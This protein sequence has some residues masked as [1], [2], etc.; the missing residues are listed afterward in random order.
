MDGGAFYQNPTYNAAGGNGGGTSGIAGVLC[1]NAK[2]NISPGYGGQAGTQTAGGIAGAQYD[3][4]YIGEDGK[5]GI[6]GTIDIKIDNQNYY[7]SGAGRW[8]M[9]W[10]WLLRKL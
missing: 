9:V 7:S 6:G 8:R 10:W 4:W 2:P 5:F 1:A 3:S